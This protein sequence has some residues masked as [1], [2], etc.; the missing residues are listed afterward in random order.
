[1]N[2]N[3]SNEMDAI[4]RFIKK[5]WNIKAEPKE[6]RKYIKNYQDYQDMDTLD[7]KALLKAFKGHGDGGV[8]SPP[9]V[10]RVS[11]PHV[12]YEDK[13]QGRKPL[14]T[15][16]GAVLG[17]GMLLG[18]RI[19]TLDPHS[20]LGMKMSFAEHAFFNMRYA[21]DPLMLKSYADELLEHLKESKKHITYEETHKKFEAIRKRILERKLHGR[22]KEYLKGKG[23]IILHNKSEGI[24]REY[25]RVLYNLT[26]IYSTRKLFEEAMERAGIRVK[27]C[28]EEG[29]DFSVS[30][31]EGKE[32]PDVEPDEEP[33]KTETRY[34]VQHFDYED[35]GRSWHVYDKIER[36]HIHTASQ[37]FLREDK[38]EPVCCT[39]ICNALN[40]ED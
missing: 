4:L 19:A 36:C 24:E 16:L 32:F 2:F 14:R 31:I 1:M 40:K 6:Y 23:E 39:R 21:E 13:G 7:E 9:F 34:E 20:D 5:R 10:T 37:G 12:A 28:G 8:C 22:F 11:L 30:L 27:S 25:Q 17:H 18:E 35:G 38:K 29:Y 3:F 26:F 15:L 33:P